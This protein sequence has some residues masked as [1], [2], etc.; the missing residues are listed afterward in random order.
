MSLQNLPGEG[1]FFGSGA[2]ALVRSKNT[3]LAL[4]MVTQTQTSETMEKQL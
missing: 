1:L 2:S 4:W 3:G